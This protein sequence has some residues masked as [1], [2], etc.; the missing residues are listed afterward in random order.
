MFT[1]VSLILCL[2]W[3]LPLFFKSFQTL[4]SGWAF[5]SGMKIAAVY[6][7]LSL[8][9]CGTKLTNRCVAAPVWTDFYQQT[10][11]YSVLSQWDYRNTSVTSDNA[12]PFRW[13]ETT[14]VRLKS[15][16]LSKTG[17]QSCPRLLSRVLDKRTNVFLSNDLQQRRGNS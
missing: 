1:L 2:T 6:C 17:F 14:R 13:H 7:C 8:F 10:R 15:A 3:T 16:A 9:Q 11:K 4:C 12:P 5:I